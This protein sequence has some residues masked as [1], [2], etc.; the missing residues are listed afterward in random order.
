MKPRDLVLLTALLAVIA[1]CGLKGSLTLPE[2]PGEVAVRPGPGAP[3]TPAEPTAPPAESD[4]DP[5]SES[6]PEPENPTG[7]SRE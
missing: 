4:A 1:G 7:T 3:A 5:E 6:E 2:K